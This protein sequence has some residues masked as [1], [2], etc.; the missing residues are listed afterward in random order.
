MFSIRDVLLFSLSLSL[1]CLLFFFFAECFLFSSSSLYARMPIC[2]DLRIS[3]RLL[4]CFY[5]CQP[6]FPTVFFPEIQQISVFNAAVAVV[7]RLLYSDTR[8]RRGEKIETE[9]KI[10]TLSSHTG[11]REKHQHIDIIHKLPSCS[12]VEWHRTPDTWKWHDLSDNSFVGVVRIGSMIRKK[13]PRDAEGFSDTLT[14]VC[15]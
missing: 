3:F 15:Q 7:E 13:F 1:V 14:I 4:A 5:Y 8:E 10:K 6:S 2:A 11:V 12:D 9:T